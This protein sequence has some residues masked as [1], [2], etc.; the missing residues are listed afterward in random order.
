MPERDELDRLIDSELARYA[1]P[2]TGLEQR[3]LAS[4]DAASS[5]RSPFFRAWQRWALAAAIAAA[6][7]LSI[8][9]PD[10]IYRKT[11]TT[12]AHVAIPEHAPA[13]RAKEITSESEVQFRPVPKVANTTHHIARASKPNHIAEKTTRPRL[14]IFPAPHPLSPEEQALVAIATARSDS[15]R[16]SLMASQRAMNAPLQI[17]AI[18]IPPITMPN[19]GNK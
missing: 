13:A 15:A 17:S 19:E 4:V 1:E 5:A 3:V 11:S 14:D 2:R 16:E 8:A 7:V 12:T 10:F 6:V 18:E 9:I